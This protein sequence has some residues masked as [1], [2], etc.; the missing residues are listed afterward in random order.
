MTV[1]L[2]FAFFLFSIVVSSNQV[3]AQS[4]PE[5]C[6]ESLRGVFHR[7]VDASNCPFI[8]LENGSFAGI[9][10]DEGMFFVTIDGEKTIYYWINT[11]TDTVIVK[12]SNQKPW[13]RPITGRQTF[14]DAKYFYY[15]FF[16]PGGELQDLKAPSKMKIVCPQPDSLSLSDDTGCDW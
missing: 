14:P 16:S 9:Q 8:K 5:K 2:K 11:Q 13:R 7:T 10:S 3:R 1:A 4:N 6:L 15:P 12:E